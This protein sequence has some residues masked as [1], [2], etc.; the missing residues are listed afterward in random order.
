M[1]IFFSK[2]FHQLFFLCKIEIESIVTS[3]NYLYSSND[4][5][6]LCIKF[7]ISVPKIISLFFPNNLIV[8]FLFNH[9]CQKSFACNISKI[10][11][12]S[13]K[14]GGTNWED[15]QTV[16]CLCCEKKIVCRRYVFQKPKKMLCYVLTIFLCKT[17]FKLCDPFSIN[18]LASDHQYTDIQIRYRK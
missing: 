13:S 15:L 18:G 5:Y 10:I 8:F 3:Y 9:F 12:W 16:N 4:W 17:R 14:L 11:K 2:S 7:L 1:N 6:D